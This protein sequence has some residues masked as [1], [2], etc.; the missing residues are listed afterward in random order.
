MDTFK[1]LYSKKSNILFENKTPEQIKD[2]KDKNK[3]L[4]LVDTFKD[5]YSKKSNSLQ[6][7]STV[8][9]DRNN[10][11]V[12][13]NNPRLMANTK[14]IPIN[15]SSDMNSQGLINVADIN[16]D[17]LK[18]LQDLRNISVQT[19]KVLA[20]N[21]EQSTFIPSMSP[22]RNRASNT[23]NNDGVRHHSLNVNRGDYGSSPYALV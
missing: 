23:D 2:V 13:N 4:S 17:Q 22:T 5:L 10:M 12:G 8:N 20:K 6:K 15:V 21:N 19:L 18:V 14:N 3:P 7:L 1:D 11:N 16:N 9:N